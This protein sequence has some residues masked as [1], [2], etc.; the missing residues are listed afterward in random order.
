[1]TVSPPGGGGGCSLLLARASTPEQA[2]SVGNQTGGRVFLFLATDDFDR[3]YKS[4]KRAGIAFV[5][6]PE[7]MPYGRVAVW[8]DLYGNRWDLVQYKDGRG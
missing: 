7:D 1:V 5:R 2:A 3:D 6:E 4:M 8:E